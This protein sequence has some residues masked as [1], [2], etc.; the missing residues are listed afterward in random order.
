MKVESA[1]KAEARTQKLI[2]RALDAHT[3]NE[4]WPPK[5]KR[6]LTPEQKERVKRAVQDRA[7][8]GK[9]IGELN[10]VPAKPV[11]EAK[12]PAKGELFAMAASERIRGEL[13][14]M[15]RKLLIV[16]AAYADGGNPSPT[17]DALAA[18]MSTT[19]PNVMWLLRS[20]ELR[21]WIKVE[22]V[23]QIGKA[24]VYKLKIH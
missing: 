22:W 20:L 1:E 2:D 8:L 13:P 23:D 11:S 21:R 3:N 16:L 15:L 18:R 12:P 24:N 7:A 19:R 6:N 17:I 5:A 9:E 10:D 4:P 14:P